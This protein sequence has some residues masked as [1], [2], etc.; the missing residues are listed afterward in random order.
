MNKDCIVVH[1]SEIGLKGKNRAQFENQLRKNIVRILS[2]TSIGPVRRDFGRII[3]SLKKD[4]DWLAIKNR[5]KKV[6]GISSFSKA[7]L[8]GTNESE[9]I[10]TAILLFSSSHIDSFR[11]NT[12]RADKNFKYTSIQLNRLL[13]KP[14]R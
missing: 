3:I 11:V 8:T 2:D 1:Y 7:I 5:L 9:I 6:F 14:M 4:S 12:K 10:S 13:M